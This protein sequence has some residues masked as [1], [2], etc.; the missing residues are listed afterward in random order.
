[1]VSDDL[2]ARTREVLGQ[3]VRR[4]LVTGGTGFVGSH[5]AKTL[6]AAGQ[7]VVVIG[8]NA[9][10][11]SPNVRFEKAD[12]RDP[13]RVASLCKNMDV[14]VHAAAH[15]SPWL[16]A[17]QLHATNVQGTKNVVEGCRHHGVKRLIHVSSTALHFSFQDAWD[18]ADDAVPPVRMACGYAES[19]AEAEQVVRGACEHGLNAFIVR[20]RAVFGPGDNNLLP[21]ILHAYDLGRLRQIGGGRNI[22]ELTFIDN[23]VLGLVLAIDHGDSGETCTIT[24][25]APVPLW[26]LLNLVLQRTGR[27]RRLR[28]IPYRAALAYAYTSEVMHR[29]GRRRG[30][31]VLT[32]YTVGLLAKSQTFSPDAARNQLGYEPI[33]TMEDAVNRTVESLAEIDDAPATKHVEVTLHTTGFTPNSMHHAERGAKR[34]PV[35]FHAMIAIIR[36][37][38]HGVI[39]LDTGYAPRFK[40]ATHR[41]PYRLLR[42]AT[43]V[44]A[45]ARQSAVAVLQRQGI[46]AESLKRIILTHFHPDHSAGLLDFP[47]AE[48]ITSRAAWA[49]VCGRRSVSAMRR[50]FLPD[51]LPDD[52]EERLCLIEHFH[53]PGFG[54]FSGCFDLFGDGT[55]KL[56]EL[57]GHAIGQIGL[58][59]QTG[60]NE[61]K[62]FVAD[63]VWTTRTIEAGLPFT[64]PFRAIAANVREA[65]RVRQKLQRFH[66]QYPEIE[67]LPTHCPEV[68]KRY[69]FD[70]AYDAAGDA[71]V[72]P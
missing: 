24:S 7:E 47:N 39:L 59:A 20:A 56:F 1:M 4:V 67:I 38:D 53:G 17:K 15:A 31:P 58:L 41:L 26:D 30:E 32:R 46:P 55:L 5:V 54:P 10:L 27:T 57:G 40:D 70:A 29:V 52:I 13:D 34:A 68:A 35:R 48:V 8:R 71:L 43:P 72:V 62:F 36:H 50:I 45:G 65:E 51:L 6:A 22:T 49:D 69:G 14:V 63:A 60:P 42:A 3:R 44:T 25:N 66:Q 9:Y 19:K 12:I 28:T 37:P 16:T 23:L 61:R 33:V 64:L 2:L 18:I 21:R 11:A